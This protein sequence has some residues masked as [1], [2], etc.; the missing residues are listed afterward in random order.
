M[1]NFGATHVLTSSPADRCSSFSSVFLFVDFLFFCSF[2]WTESNL[3]QLM[4]C[5]IPPDATLVP[6]MRQ[7]TS[8]TCG[9]ASLQSILYYW[10]V[11]DGREDTLA[12]RVGATPEDGTSIDNLVKGAHTFGLEAFSK[13]GL[14]LD[15]LRAAQRE[16]YTLVLNVQAWT[17]VQPPVDWR[18]VWEDGHYVVLVGIDDTNVFQHW[19]EIRLCPNGRVRR[20]LA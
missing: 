6:L 9:V 8:H 10:R 5:S 12:A 14:S 4:T 11:Y 18:T 17:D 15:N 13:E 7:A 16:G 3:E 2:S 1:G 20:P 19:G